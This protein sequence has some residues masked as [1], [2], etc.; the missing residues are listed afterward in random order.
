[1]KKQVKSLFKI[2]A[3]IVITVVA[4]VIVN[5]IMDAPEW[6]YWDRFTEPEPMDVPVVLSTKLNFDETGVYTG[7]IRRA[8]EKAEFR[9]RIINRIFPQQETIVPSSVRLENVRSEAKRMLNDHGGDVLVYGAVG[10][11]PN[12][13]LIQ[14][15]GRGLDG[16]IERGMEIDVGDEA[17]SNNVIRVLEELATESGLEQF[18]GNRAIRAGMSLEEFM[19]ASENKLSVLNEIT[20]TD[21][22]KERTELGIATVQMTRARHQNDVTTIRKIKKAVE[23]RVGK[24]AR[25]GDSRFHK[26]Q[27]MTLAD[28]YMI[29]GLMKGNT[30]I[31]EEG[32]NIAMDGGRGILEEMMR[33]DD[34]AVQRPENASF[35]HWLLMTILVLACDDQEAMQRLEILHLEYSDSAAKQQCMTRADEFRM[36]WPL[37]VLNKKPDRAELKYFGAVLATSRDFGL[38]TLDHWQDPFVHARRLVTKRLASMEGSDTSEG[39]SVGPSCPSLIRWMDMKGWDRPATEEQSSRVN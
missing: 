6:V 32:M 27:R 13:I 19:D 15:F 31:I 3:A 17:W 26:V 28:L 23:E 11:K 12:A 21:Y 36:L 39:V 5:V 24:T 7:E 1:M 34:S 2:I 10:A 37:T 16:Y 25:I 22:L 8:L 9:Y 30:D 4:G 35:A 33:E 14:F 20:N 38:G 18:L 29:E